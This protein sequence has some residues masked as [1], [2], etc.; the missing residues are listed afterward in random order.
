M[1]LNSQQIQEILPHRDPFL[2]I[3]QV[4]A[5]EPGSFAEAVRR[6]SAENQVF[7]G[8]FPGHPVMP[9]VLMLEAMA[10]TA[11]VALLSLEENR[12]KG[13]LL[14]GVRNAKFLKPVVPDTTLVLRS[15]L[16]KMLGNMGTV[17]ASATEGGVPCATADLSF[18]IV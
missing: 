2:L 1:E 14:T 13:V 4:T 17:R 9:G 6:V 16:V 11:A 3:D 15:E 10:Q 18:A 7:S 12:G 8:H 5:C